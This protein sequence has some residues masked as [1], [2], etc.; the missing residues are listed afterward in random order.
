MGIS[1]SRKT[2]YVFVNV[3]EK[4]V[5]HLPGYKTVGDKHYSYKIPELQNLKVYFKRTN[6]VDLPDFSR[7]HTTSKHDNFKVDNCCCYCKCCCINRIFCRCK[8][9]RCLFFYT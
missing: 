8:L 5:Q 6:E 7:Y 4:N 3:E 2:D 9:S 1:C